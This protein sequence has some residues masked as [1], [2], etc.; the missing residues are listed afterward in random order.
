MICEFLVYSS[1]SAMFFHILCLIFTM[2]YWLPPYNNM[3]HHLI[4][5]YS[6]Q[7]AVWI[8]HLVI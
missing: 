2:L 5:F 1:D 7:L 8:L 6:F 4:A 3:N